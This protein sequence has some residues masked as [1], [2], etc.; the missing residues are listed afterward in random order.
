MADST[1]DKS[2]R[3]PRKPRG[4]APARRRDRAAT[5]ERL[6]RAAVRSFSKNGF[7]RTTTR[8]IARTA[9]VNESLI[10]R[11]FGTKEGLLKAIIRRHVASKRAE[12]LGYPPQST[13]EAELV[14]YTR[15]LMAQQHEDIDMVRII[16]SRAIVDAKLRAELSVENTFTDQRLARRL[17]QLRDSGAV[18]PSADLQEVAYAVNTIVYGTKTFSGLLLGEPVESTSR[19]VEHLIGRYAKG[20]IASFAKPD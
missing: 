7:E 5:E 12:E 19:R 8:I 18:S 6:L 13:L 11:Y 1:G 3:Q 14:A 9:G 16:L 15:W 10:I 17:A 2:E 20:L 4:R